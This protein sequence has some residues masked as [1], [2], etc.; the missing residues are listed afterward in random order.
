LQ[1]CQ[2]APAVLVQ[3][4]VLDQLHQDLGGVS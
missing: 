4:D 1:G 3:A 2:T